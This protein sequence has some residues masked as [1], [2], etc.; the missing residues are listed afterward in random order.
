MSKKIVVI[1][2]GSGGL[3]SAT[4]LAKIGYDVVLVEGH[5]IGG[6]CTHYGC[7]PSKTLIQESEKLASFVRNFGEYLKLT[8][9]K[10]LKLSKGVLQKVRDKVTEFAEHESKDWLESNGV[11]F[12]HGYAKFKSENSL[13]ISGEYLKESSEEFKSQIKADQLE[14]D[15]DYCIIATGSK[16]NIPEI[17]NIFETPFLTNQ[18]VFNLECAPESIAILGA[19]ATGIELANSFA[20]LGSKVCIFTRSERM[21]RDLD[22][23]IS[24]NLKVY[25]ESLGV[26]FITYDSFKVSHKEKKFYLEVNGKKIVTDELLVA[27]GRKPN[28]NLD[29]EN[30]SIK[31]DKSGIKVSTKM[32]TTNSSVYALGDVVSDYPNFTHFADYSG[33]QLVK[34]FAL[35][36][37]LKLPFN[38]FKIDKS[39]NPEVIYG[40][41]EAAAFGLTET[42]AKEM[43]GSKVHVYY[44]YS[45]DF[46][47]LKIGSAECS[48]IKVVTVGLKRILVGVQI[49]N[50]R[51]GEMLP[52]FQTL[53][54]MKKSILGLSGIIRAYP[55]FTFGYKNLFKKIFYEIIGRG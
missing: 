31:Y 27:T 3:T 2:A 24:S 26:D 25:L 12:V 47:R 16:T 18:N 33:S 17:P 37:Y 55:S 36:K 53:I 15:F 38:Y 29:L 44:L 23:E 1:G 50:P 34:N 5:K 51:A 49:L 39:K 30:A 41:Y 21:L 32:Q 35:R 43:Y 45:K 8:K 9:E 14:L 54:E 7:V 40:D 10:S 22:P 46:D 52:E 48:M 28:I 13:I 20:N 11:R 4:G 42:V 6:D 19:G